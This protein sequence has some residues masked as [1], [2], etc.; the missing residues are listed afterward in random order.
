MAPVTTTCAAGRHRRSL[1][2]AGLRCVLRVT[3]GAYTFRF[4]VQRRIY[5]RISVPTPLQWQM[6][7]K[8]TFFPFTSLIIS[9]L[10][11][12]NDAPFRHV[13]FCTDSAVVPSV[14]SVKIRAIT[15]ILIVT[16]SK[17]FLCFS[18]SFFNYVSRPMVANGVVSFLFLANGNKYLRTRFHVIIRIVLWDRY[19][20]WHFRLVPFLT[21]R[22]C[23]GFFN[24]YYHSG[25]DLS[26][27]KGRL[28]VICNWISRGISLPFKDGLMYRV[29]LRVGRVEVVFNVHVNYFRG[30]SSYFMARANRLYRLTKEATRV[31]VNSRRTN[32]D[33][34]FRS[35]QF[36]MNSIRRKARLIPV[37]NFRSS[38]KRVSNFHRIQISGARPFLLSKASRR[39]ARR[40]RSIRVCSVFI[41]ATTTCKMLQAW[42]I[43]KD[44]TYGYG[45]RAFGTSSNEIKR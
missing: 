25:E 39:Q 28:V 20:R 13:I 21:A 40:F 24:V 16:Y 32:K 29:D 26:N 17:W 36:F 38:N 12:S 4:I 18:T 27:I 9:F 31:D 22:R 2:N 33:Q 45:S 41:V 1:F 8:I 44:G 37:A 11:L 10:R 6:S 15:D 7:N 30:E 42:F 43:V 34:A 19:S 3:K 14:R 35:F 5:S 23:F